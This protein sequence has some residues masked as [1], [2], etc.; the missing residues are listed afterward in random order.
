MG[1]EH[2]P[3]YVL[4]DVGPSEEIRFNQLH[5]ASDVEVSP[6]AV[7]VPSGRPGEWTPIPAVAV[8]ISGPSIDGPRR[9]E[10]LRLLS[11]HGEW[12]AAIA[13]ESGRVV[14]GHLYASACKVVGRPLMVR[15][16]PGTDVPAV[17]RAFGRPY[18]E[19]SY[20]HLPRTTWF[21]TMAQRYRLRGE[22]HSRSTLYEAAIIP[23]LR[24]GMRV[25]DFGCG[26]GDYVRML[27][28]KGVD[29]L[30]VEF[31][32]RAKGSLNI[33]IG[34]A[35]RMVDALCR[36]LERHG[37]FDMV[38]CDSVLNSVDSLQAESDVL[39]CVNAL[40][41]PGGT[42]AFSGRSRA[43]IERVTGGK[44]KVNTAKKEVYFLDADGFSAI[45]QG[46]GWLYQKF[47]TPGQARKL[48]AIHVGASA[49]YEAPITPSWHVVGS[50]TV[51]SPDREGAL[52]REFDMPLPGGRRFGRSA[53]ILAAWRASGHVVPA[54]TVIA[55]G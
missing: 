40:C 9:N 32:R 29:I 7:S 17:L 20:D 27:A 30:G 39:A 23:R 38:A 25:L 49:M 4:G 44:T 47:H 3:A 14:V 8:S 43:F 22:S 10:I 35:H 48:A 6:I 51:D 1:I 55:A 36:T 2:A 53:D 37:P 34:A 50:K 21:Q 31:Y 16:V 33:D 52:A 28:R 24:P 54:E 46:R 18:G 19:F 26:Q 5:N 15:Y 45:H 12:S 41:R 11:R 42:I 13:D